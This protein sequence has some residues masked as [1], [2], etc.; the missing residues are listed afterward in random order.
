MEVLWA[1]GPDVTTSIW[2][3]K[4][5]DNERI[6]VISARENRQYF[7]HLCT[8]TWRDKKDT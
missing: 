4:Y 3:S 8:G 2:N 5:K 7:K 1:T 6:K